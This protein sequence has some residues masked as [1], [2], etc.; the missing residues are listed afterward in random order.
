MVGSKIVRSKQRCVAEGLGD[1]LTGN[2]SFLVNA[3]VTS[4]FCSR[5]CGVIPRTL[6]PNSRDSYLLIKTV[7]NLLHSWQRRRIMIPKSGGDAFIVNS[8]TRS[9]NF[10]I[11]IWVHEEGRVRHAY[12]PRTTQPGQL[13]NTCI[14]R[15]EKLGGAAGVYRVLHNIGDFNSRFDREISRL[16]TTDSTHRF[17]RSRAFRWCRNLKIGDL[18]YIAVCISALQSVILPLVVLDYCCRWCYSFEVLVIYFKGIVVRRFRRPVLVKTLSLRGGQLV[19]LCL[20]EAMCYT[21]SDC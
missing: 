15:F 20:A 11:K 21:C 13:R 17:S 12:E 14:S 3:R 5:P 10:E 1:V 19:R 2:D 6:A 7:K 9:V 4:T 18:V 16:D 8:N